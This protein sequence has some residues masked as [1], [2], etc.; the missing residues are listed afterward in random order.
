MFRL[1]YISQI[2]KDGGGKSFIP[3]E[4]DISEGNLCPPLDTG[5]YRAMISH[6][7]KMIYNLLIFYFDNSHELIT[8][9]TILFSN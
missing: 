9:S 7:G 1:S 6:C 3:P 4:W 8:R 2:K 5:L